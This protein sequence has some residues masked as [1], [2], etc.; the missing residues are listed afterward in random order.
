M[1][2][3]PGSLWINAGR[4]NWKV[5]LPGT[6]KRKN[7]PLRAPG[8]KAALAEAKGRDLAESI[9]ARMWERAQREASMAEVAKTATLD[10][11]ISKFLGWAETYYRR[12]DGTS[13]RE[14]GN[15]EYA[16]NTLKEQ[17]GNMLIDDLTY[18]H[19]LDSRDSLIRE[20]LTRNTINQRVGIWKRFFAWALENRL[21]S[22]S[23]KMEAW[24]ITSLKANR[25]EAKENGEVRPVTDEDIEATVKHLTPTPATMVRVQRLTGMRPGELCAMRPRDIEKRKGLWIYRPAHHKTKHKGSIRVVVLGPQAIEGLKPY[26]QKTKPNDSLFE[27]GLAEERERKREGDSPRERWIFIQYGKVIRR[28]CKKAGVEPWSPNQLRHACATAVRRGFGADAARSVL[29]HSSGSPRIT[30]RYTKEAI[31]EEVIETVGKIMKKI[32]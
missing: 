24:A 6:E 30:D 26:V 14:A 22:A 23:T 16:L 27:Q 17:H 32:G 31:E 1:K 9:A 8:Q 4:W 5:R 29:G 7:Y 11:C 15:C 10:V 13:T 18:Q 28:A 21:C 25:S 19:L 2:E 20:G 3:L 12:S